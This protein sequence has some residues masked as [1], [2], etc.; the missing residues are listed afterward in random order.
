MD[1]EMS[2]WTRIKVRLAIM[3]GRWSSRI[4]D[5]LEPRDAIVVMQRCVLSNTKRNKKLAGIREEVRR[6]TKDDGTMEDTAMK[7]DGRCHGY[8]RRRM[9]FFRRLIERFR[10]AFTAFRSWVPAPDGPYIR[11]PKLILD[12]L[13]SDDW[14]RIVRHKRL[15]GTF[16]EELQ[17]RPETKE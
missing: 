10:A 14:Q 4:R 17:G 1:K 15:N 16:L 3:F 2:L 5:S 11:D 9:S 7:D 8:G 13:E 12:R 6:I